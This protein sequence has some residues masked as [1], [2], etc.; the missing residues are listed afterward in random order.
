MII[1]YRLDEEGYL[2]GEFFEAQHIHMCAVQ[3]ACADLRISKHNWLYCYAI[4]NSKVQ[5]AL[6][7]CA[8]HIFYI[9]IRKTYLI[10]LK[11][12]IKIIKVK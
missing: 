11:N 9:N 4:D 10:L 8:H 2:M 3:F 5:S 12:L 1:V 6:L 7:N